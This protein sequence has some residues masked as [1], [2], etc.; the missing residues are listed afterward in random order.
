MSDISVFGERV[1]QLRTQLKLS[2]RDFS[3]KVGITA[4]ALS[5]YENG[6]KNPSV[7]VAIKDRKS[8]V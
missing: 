7:N 3:E 6:Q 1:K 5:A 8:V 2:Q 4:S